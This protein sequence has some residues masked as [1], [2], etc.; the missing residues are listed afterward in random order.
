MTDLRFVDLKFADQMRETDHRWRWRRLSRIWQAITTKQRGRGEDTDVE[1]RRCCRRREEGGKTVA[2]RCRGGPCFFLGHYCYSDSSKSARWQR[3]QRSMRK[4]AL[5]WLVLL[6]VADHRRLRSTSPEVGRGRGGSTE[7]GR[8]ACC[9]WRRWCR[10]WSI[11]RVS[12]L[13]DYCR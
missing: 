4:K 6:E 9:C 1:R 10:G 7:G 13:L 2:T 3:Q 5:I 12:R 8:G 11:L